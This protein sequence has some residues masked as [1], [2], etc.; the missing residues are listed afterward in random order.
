MDSVR[1][2]LRK[3]PFATRL[4]KFAMKRLLTGRSMKFPTFDDLTHESTK[5]TLDY[6]RFVTLGLAIQ[7]VLSE[8][9]EGNFAEVGVYRGDMSEFISRL[10]PSRSF[11]LFDSFDGFPEEDLE[12][13]KK[14]DRRF[15]DTS[16]EFVLRRLH[17]ESRTQIRKGHVPETLR[18]LEVERFAFVL[19]D[20]DLYE[21]TRASLEFFYPRMSSGGYII[22]H[23]YNSPES[24]WACKRAMDG[25]LQ[26]KPEHLVEIG[27]I[28]GT[29]MFR[30]G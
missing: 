15:R 20:L 26:D 13:G 2:I 11:F 19:I 5:G 6:F 22:L 17:P 30:K 23:D 10:A 9:V 18:G 12:L 8:D 1:S 14:H 3:I 24:N 4:R 29:V 25:F 28:W 7:R 21:P 27:D 16:V